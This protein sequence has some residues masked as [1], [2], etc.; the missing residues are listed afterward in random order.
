MAATVYVIGGE[1]WLATAVVP[2]AFDHDYTDVTGRRWIKSRGDW[3]ARP[4]TY[5]FRTTSLVKE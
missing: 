2:N 5:S 1:R 3:A 4:V